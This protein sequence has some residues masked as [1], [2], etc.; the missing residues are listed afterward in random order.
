[1]VEARR[2]ISIDPLKEDVGCKH[3]SQQYTHV[4]DDRVRWHVLPFIPSLTFSLHP[5]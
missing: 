3:I 4:V 5:P 1:M 2:T